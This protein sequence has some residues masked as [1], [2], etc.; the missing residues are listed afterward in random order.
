M[1]PAAGAFHW[2][3]Q[4]SRDDLSFIYVYGKQSDRAIHACTWLKTCI[5][6][7]V[8]MRLDERAMVDFVGRANRYN[9][10]V[11]GVSDAD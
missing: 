4:K 8:Y 6:H 2:C 10:E 3:T 5:F 11:W 7:A 9:L 1:C